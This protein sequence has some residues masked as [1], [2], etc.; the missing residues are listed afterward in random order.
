MK[1]IPNLNLANTSSQGS[2]LIVSLVILLIMTILGLSAMQTTVLQERMAGNMKDRNMAF[3]AAEAALRAGENWVENNAA[4]LQGARSLHSVLAPNPISSWDGNPNS[5]KLADFDAPLAGDPVFY[6]GPPKSIRVGIQLP[7][8]FRFVY[9]VT[10][11]SVGGV[12]ST[13]VILESNY[14]PFN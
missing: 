13:V 4:S 14:E 11:R 5:G 12:D 6:A 9:P 10:A 2:A 3:Q 1:S 7:P 8:Q